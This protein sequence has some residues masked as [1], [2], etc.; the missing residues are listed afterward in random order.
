MV[1][2]VQSWVTSEHAVGRPSVVSGDLIQCVDQKIVK[3]GASQFQNFPV[4]L[5]TYTLLSTTLSQLG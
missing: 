2:N 3:D 1:Q 4:D 5:K